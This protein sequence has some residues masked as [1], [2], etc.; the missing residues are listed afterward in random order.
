MIVWHGN[1]WHG[2][3][4]RRVPGLRVSIPVLMARPFMRTDEDLF[5]RI[6]DEVLQRNSQR[7]AY[8]VQQ[9]IVY[10]FH[11]DESAETRVTRATRNII[12]YG[13]ES[14]GVVFADR[15]YMHLH[16]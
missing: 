14:G 6:P 13:K 15:G 16:G 7:F 11:S 1:T 5:N 9:G 12:A 10:G 3:F 4:N 2:A 8:L